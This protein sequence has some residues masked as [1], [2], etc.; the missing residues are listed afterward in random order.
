ME[1]KYLANTIRSV[2]IEK[3]TGKVK[4]YHA[5]KERLNVNLYSKFLYFLKGMIWYIV[6][7]G[8]VIEG[9]NRLIL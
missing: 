9:S 2:L 6:V 4:F 1:W 3:N 8:G 7:K 5:E